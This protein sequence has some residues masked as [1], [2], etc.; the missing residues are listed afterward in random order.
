MILI[1]DTYTQDYR[2]LKESMDVI[3]KECHIVSFSH[4]R[5]EAE[6]EF[7]IYE[8]FINKTKNEKLDEKSLYYAFINMPYLWAVRADGVN[9][10]IYDRNYKKAEIYFTE[11]IE[12]RNVLRIEWMDEEDKVYRVDHYNRYGDKF[13]SEYNCNGITQSRE[14]Y[15]HSQQLV[16]L[17]Q[18]MEGII[19]LF[20]N[21]KII[22]RFVDYSEFLQAYLNDTGIQDVSI[23]FG[24]EK[25]WKRFKNT[26][27]EVLKVLDVD[28]NK[29][30]WYNKIKSENKF[31]N[32]EAFILTGT[33]QVE[34]LEELI[35]TFPNI[36]FHIA[37]HTLMSEKLLKLK[38]YGNVL[39]YPAIS[40]TVSED[41]FEKCG[42]Y[43]D[44]NHWGEIYD[45]VPMAAIHGLLIMAFDT[46]VHHRE[47]TLSEHIF[48]TTEIE[49][50]KQ[51]LRLLISDPFSYGDRLYRQ[52]KL[53]EQRRME[54]LKGIES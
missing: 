53:L 28:H 6:D 17:E 44:I 5:S 7:S 24:N 21:G 40:R 49:Q 35:Q 30:Y 31:G 23:M 19:T 27:M 3:G 15:N 22:K 18:V 2:A 50:M 47:L 43:L 39:L 12:R 11:P 38:S 42:L 29:V 4:I 32:R 41:L 8:Y 16:L 9:G 20:Q 37:A 48:K 54:V 33:D 34:S 46:T 14:F 10:A 1:V 45:A 25:I 52:G 51:T 13:C 36:Q 26:N